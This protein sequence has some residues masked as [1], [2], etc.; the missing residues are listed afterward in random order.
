MC[1]RRS[2]VA[3]LKNI[4]EDQRDENVTEKR[5]MT[6]RSVWFHDH[7]LGIFLS[8]VIYCK[9]ITFGDVFFLVPLIWR[10]ISIRQIKTSLNVHL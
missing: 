7:T 4:L 6:D 2:D 1:S 5:P 9:R 3:T 10:L 8:K